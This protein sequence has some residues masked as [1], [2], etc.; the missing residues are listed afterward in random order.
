VI[1]DS[2]TKNAWA[3]VGKLEKG[4]HRVFRSLRS[5]TYGR[6]AL[7][8]NSGHY[9]DETDDGILWLRVE[10]PLELCAPRGDYLPVEIPLCKDCETCNRNAPHGPTDKRC[11]TKTATG[12][13]G[14]LWLLQNRIFAK[15]IVEDG[16][17]L[18]LKIIRDAFDRERPTEDRVVEALN[19]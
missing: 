2:N 14:A 1:R 4:G 11:R 12:A 19:R 13:D 9:P 7:A 6:L 5:A 18:F 16:A 15:I 8:D 3:F 17:P 10:E